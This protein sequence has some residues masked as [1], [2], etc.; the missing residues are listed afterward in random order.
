[1]VRPGRGVAQQ[2]RASAE[3]PPRPALAVLAG[4]AQAELAEAVRVKRLASVDGPRLRL[5]QAAPLDE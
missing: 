4:A 2:H 1:M 3:L 5:A